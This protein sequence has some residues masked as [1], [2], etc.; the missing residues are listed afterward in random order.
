[1]CSIGVKS[2][3]PISSGSLA[4]R[5]RTNGKVSYLGRKDLTKMV[6]QQIAAQPAINHPQRKPTQKGLAL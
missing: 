2:F 3:L 5:R 4:E 6:K 1:M